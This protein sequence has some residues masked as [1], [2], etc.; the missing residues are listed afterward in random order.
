VRDGDSDVAHC[1][2]LSIVSSIDTPAIESEAV[3]S[4]PGLAL[5]LRIW[6]GRNIWLV[7]TLPGLIFMLAAF[8]YPLTRMLLRSFFDPDFTLE[9]YQAMVAVDAY[10]RVLIN[11]FRISVI[12]T[13]LAL[14]LGY[15]VAYVLAHA[16][17][18]R[19]SILMIGIVLPLWTS[20]LVRTFAW[21]IILGRSGPINDLLRWL[22]IIEQP[23]QLLFNATAVYIGTVHIMLPFII[24]PMY[25]VMQ[26]ID[27][28]LVRA[29]KSVGAS[30]LSAFIHIYFPLSLPGVLAGALLVF[31]LT[32]G[33]YIT[34]AILGSPRE[35]MIA[36]LIETQGR[37]AL[38]WGF[39]SALSV[40]LLVATLIILYVY[41]R[42]FG[43]D[44][45]VAGGR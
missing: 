32:T 7:L 42:V 15:P 45:P 19:A 34:P 31:I 25:S 13:I 30:P 22:G 23:I 29:A 17:G 18:V 20:E 10:A 21:T 43:L 40:A 27:P 38:N 8:A 11:T 36:M 33:F 44:R 35:T 5:R 3:Q 14:V 4:R 6:T 2:E 1:L 12:V 16:G 28:G 24:L 26:S 9:H 41:N 39:A 37:R